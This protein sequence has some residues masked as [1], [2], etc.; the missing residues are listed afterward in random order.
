M[1]LMGWLWISCE[2]CGGLGWIWFGVWG[3]SVLCFVFSFASLAR[4]MER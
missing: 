4:F 1:G 3:P 2:G